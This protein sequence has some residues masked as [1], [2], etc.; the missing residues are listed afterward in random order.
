[1]RGDA[2]RFLLLCAF[3][4][5]WFLRTRKNVGYER[6]FGGSFA[7]LACHCIAEWI[8]RLE[9]EDRCMCRRR[10][11]FTMSRAICCSIRRME[12]RSIEHIGFD[13]RLVI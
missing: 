8:G 7:S 5:S 10:I 11:C 6:D 2:W 1:M 9:L 12:F 13:L 4:R 3:A